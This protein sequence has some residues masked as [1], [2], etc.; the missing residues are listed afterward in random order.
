V[1]ALLAALGPRATSEDEATP[2]RRV[3]ALVEEFGVR[4]G[5]PGVAVLVVTPEGVRVKKGYGLANLA[6]RTPITTATTFELASVSKQFTGAAVLLLVQRGKVRLADDVRKHL[7]EVPLY[8]AAHPITV[9]HLSRHTSGL[10]D[11]LAWEGEPPAE[12]PYLTNADALVEL[13]RRRESSP[14]LSVPGEEYA[15]SNTGYMVLAALVERVSGLSFGSFLAKEFF[16]PLGMKTAWV[17]ESPRVPTAPTAVGYARE[18]GA[19]KATW[20]A[21]TAERHEALLTTGDGGVW[22]SLDDLAAWDRGLRS[23]TP[24]RPET[25]TGALA[26]GRTR[27]GE[28]LAYAMGWQVE[29]DDEG[30]VV[31]MS[32]DGSWQGFESHVGHDVRREVTVVVLSN[33]RGFD[34]EGLAEAVGALFRE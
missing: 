32:H 31:A 17:H 23:G 33:R 22:A 3:D 19:W 28:R 4:G 18:G 26:P 1:A 21:P 30:A 7:P 20:S 14:L 34:A 8:D 9:D 16:G 6:R 12:R 2:E 5:G 11:Y 27:G 25:L 29:H 15:Y 24:L 10:P 13:A